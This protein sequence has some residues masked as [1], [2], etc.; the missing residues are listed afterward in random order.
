MATFTDEKFKVWHVVLSVSEIREVRAAV[1]YDL[2]K[3]FTPEGMG[4]LE[5]DP[6]L[7]VDVLWVLCGSQARAANIDER[8]FASRLVGDAIG[9]AFEAL[10]VAACDF[11]PRARRAVVEKLRAKVK[12]CERAQLDLIESKIEQITLAEIMDG[13]TPKSSG[14]L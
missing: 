12:D 1:G 10:S 9:D 5:R 3:L 13:L 7:L 6:V 11:L 8:E 2:A 14:S 4:E